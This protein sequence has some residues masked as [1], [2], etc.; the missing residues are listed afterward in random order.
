MARAIVTSL[1][2]SKLNQLYMWP[3][4]FLAAVCY[5]FE[6]RDS[7]PDVC[8]CTIGC[9]RLRSS[10]TAVFGEHALALLLARSVASETHLQQEGITSQLL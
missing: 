1:L 7:W 4:N 5:V 6:H 9:K 3:V 2:I 10:A 8:L